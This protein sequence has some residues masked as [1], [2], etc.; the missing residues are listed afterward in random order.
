MKNLAMRKVWIGF[1]VLLIVLL[2]VGLYTA[3]SIRATREALEE[4]AET[5]GEAGAAVSEMKTYAGEIGDGT[6]GYVETDDPGYRE[7]V[8]ESRIGFE[9]AG[10]RFEGLASADESE[11]R[12]DEIQALYEEYVTLGDTLMDENDE[13]EAVKARVD[14]GFSSINDILGEEIQQDVASQG[15]DGLK[16]GQEVASMSGAADGVKDSLTSYLREPE[17]DFL[18]LAS[19][20]AGDFKEA[21]GR[22]RQLRITEE[23]S[24]Q[25]DELETLFD[26]SIDEIN[27]A[28]DLDESIL[29]NEQEFSDLRANLEGALDEEAQVQRNLHAAEARETTSQALGETQTRILLAL[30]A[31]L[32]ALAAILFVGSGVVARLGRGIGRFVGRFTRWPRVAAGRLRRGEVGVE[33]R[34]LLVGIVLAAMLWVTQSVLEAYVFEE[35]DFLG[36]LFPLRAEDLLSRGLLAAALI[37]FLAYL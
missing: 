22:Y 4:E 26:E 30:A 33:R 25:A 16:E 1:G 17:Q 35:S 9:E 5:G 29:A 19:T 37:A 14:E 31:I 28:V 6:L 13:R 2:A 3:D 36:A 18:D 24:D 32:I 15:S 23:E 27:V 12:G 11:G 8:G 7:E 20:S 10:T 34:L 21:L